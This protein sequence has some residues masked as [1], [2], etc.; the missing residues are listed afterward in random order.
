MTL[1]LR[2][3]IAAVLVAALSACAGDKLP[4]VYVLGD[5][6]PA[7]PAT[8]SELDHPIVEVERV[9]LPDYLDTTDIVTRLPDGRIVARPTARWGERLSVGVTRAVARGLEARLPLLAVT[10]TAPLEP[11]RWQ[12]LIDIESFEAEAGGQVVLT[13]RWTVL[14]GSRGEQLREEKISLAAPGGQGSDTELVAAMNQLVDQLVDRIA[15][16]L[17]ADPRR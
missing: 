8:V 12:L 15:P 14:G 13:A 7:K 5:P 9:R 1:G 11:P 2:M 6:A 17:D 3:G 4:D 10:T 16:A